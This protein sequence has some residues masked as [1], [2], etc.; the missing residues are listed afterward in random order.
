[1]GAGGLQIRAASLT[2]E[3]RS[4]CGRGAHPRCRGL[5]SRARHLSRPLGCRL[6]VVSLV[7][8]SVTFLEPLKPP[9]RANRPVT[10]VPVLRFYSVKTLVFSACTGWHVYAFR[11]GRQPLRPPIFAMPET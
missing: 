5:R 9:A 7:G 8:K 2:R 3:P 1:I 4:G 10:P 6:A 11:A